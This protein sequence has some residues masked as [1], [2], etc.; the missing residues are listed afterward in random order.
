MKYKNIKT[1][2]DIFISILSAFIIL[3]L[4]FILY[5]VFKITTKGSFLYW[6]KRVGKN[7]RIFEMPKI[8]TMKI[9]TPQIATNLLKNPDTYLI[10]LGPFLRKFSL[11]ELPQIWSILLGDMSFVGPRPALFNQENLIH[12]R[13]KYGIDKLTPGLTGWA[14]ING[15]DDI[16]IEKKVKLDIY[17][18]NNYSFFFDLKIMFLTFFKILKKDNIIH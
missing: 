15:R 8:R 6:S 5:I 18:L 16:S 10:P 13:K 11:D 7:G 14:Q 9:N 17:Y 2:F 4:I 1:I 12:F 3:P